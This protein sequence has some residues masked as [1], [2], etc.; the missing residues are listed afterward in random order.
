M[1]TEKQLLLLN[2]LIFR[3]EFTNGAAEGKTVGELMQNLS[4]SFQQEMTPEEWDEIYKMVNSDPEIL[5]LRITKPYYDS[6]TESKMA[7]F[8]DGN[9]QA[10]AVFK[11]TGTNEWRDN[12]MAGCMADSPQQIEAKNW[13]D[14]LPYNNIVVSGH[15]KG[16]N[17]AMYVAITSDKAG[18]CYAF[19]GE[20]FSREFL[21]KYADRIEA[22]KGDIY[23]IANSK[24]Y[25]NVLFFCVAG[26][27]IYIDN[28]TGVGS[29]K[30]YHCPNAL[31]RYD[32]NGNIVYDL[33]TQ[34]DSN[35]PLMQMLNRFTEYVLN[36]VPNAE[37]KL[38]LNVMGEIL[39]QYVGGASQEDMYQIIMDKFGPEGVEVLM[40]Y[41]LA[42]MRNLQATDPDT[43]DTYCNLLGDSD[44]AVFWGYVFSALGFSAERLFGIKH[45]KE[46]FRFMGSALNELFGKHTRGRD[47]S[48]DTMNMIIAKAREVEEEPFWNITRWDCWYRLEKIRGQ[49]NWDNYAG[50]V[51]EYYRKIIDINGASAK[52][53]EEI[54]EKVYAIDNEYSGK[55]EASRQ[56]LNSN[57][58]SKIRE[59]TGRF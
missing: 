57:V 23:L 42:F 43:Y 15:S 53:M 10:Y 28:S 59:L 17:K 1:L 36:N 25:V 54:M 32:E 41:M 9:G 24:D 37:K 30:E 44:A 18:K 31:F 22:R 48:L 34:I 7:C 19:D 5:N 11:G 16:G 13:F 6:D 12:A 55:M 2:N 52:E 29:I 4:N 40:R 56:R 26:H 3:K 45:I 46:V 20:G 50:K 21:E 14:S 51:D 39:T 49:L 35:D 47:F 33:G 38:L 58:T 8:V 27:V